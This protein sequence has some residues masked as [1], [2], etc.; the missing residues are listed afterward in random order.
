MRYGV[1]TIRDP[2]ERIK[3]LHYIHAHLESGGA[4]ILSAGGPR[5]LLTAKNGGCLVEMATL[6]RTALLLDHIQGAKLN[7]Y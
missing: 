2:R 1:E 5:D 3:L 7:F 4:L 6:P